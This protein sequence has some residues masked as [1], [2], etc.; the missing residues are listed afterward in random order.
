MLKMSGI[1]ILLFTSILV[2]RE[3][4][5]TR[6]RRLALCEELLR[7]VSFLRLQIGCYLRPTAEVAR[8]F[9]SDD[10]SACGFLSDE[11]GDDLGRSFLSSGAPKIVGKECTRIVASLLSSLGSG[12]LNDEIG[13]IDAHRAELSTLVDGERDETARQIRLIR[14]LTASAS[15][16]LIILIV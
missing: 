6:R 5:E 13:L 12:Y 14:T 9:R 4:V 16:G 11:N 3:L 8:Q 10:L 2:S 15:I 7:F 1:C